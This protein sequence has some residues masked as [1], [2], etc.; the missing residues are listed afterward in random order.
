[1][2]EGSGLAVG[3]GFL[4]KYLTAFRIN[5]IRRR[6]QINRKPT[7]VPRIETSGRI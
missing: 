2:A 6:H 3:C 1:L 4:E 7:I 5:I